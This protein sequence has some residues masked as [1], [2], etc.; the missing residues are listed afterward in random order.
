[1]IRKSR[2]TARCSGERRSPGR[3]GRRST[4]ATRNRI[5]RATAIDE[6]RK[7]SGPSER[8]RLGGL[9]LARR[10]LL[11]I[12]TNGRGQAGRDED[13]E[14]DLREHERGVVGVELGAG[15]E[16][17]REDPVRG[18]GPSRSSRSQ[19]R[20]D[21]GALGQEPADQRPQRGSSGADIATTTNRATTRRALGASAL[22]A[23]RSGGDDR[24]FRLD[25]VLPGLAEAVD[26][27]G[28]E[29]ILDRVASAAWIAPSQPI[30]LPQARQAE[31][32]AVSVIASATSGGRP[33]GTLTI[34]RSAARWRREHDQIR[35]RRA[36]R[37][38]STSASW[39][40]RLAR[41]PALPATGLLVE[42]RERP[43]ARR[44]ER[45]ARSAGRAAT[46]SS[47][48]R[49]GAVRRASG[50]RARRT[51]AATA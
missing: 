12:G 24:R 41:F 50:S 4:G 6:D 22:T 13:V 3:R 15:A 16:R 18:R 28:L 10:R 14:G 27:V 45:A 34:A 51:I 29:P 32:G 42:D 35:Q 26:L 49:A 39:S 33:L 17:L 11:K 9:V 7:R 38:A 25:P 30:P 46:R 40:G 48:A 21:E 44:L 36:P 31:R 37:V 23:P 2:C 47:S 8:S 19:D 43:L 20:Q 5:A 1:M